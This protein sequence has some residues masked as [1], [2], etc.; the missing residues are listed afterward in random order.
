[1]YGSERTDDPVT[2]PNRGRGGGRGLRWPLLLGIAAAALLI[3][4][5]VFAAPGHK[6]AGHGAAPGKVSGPVVG[7]G[8]PAFWPSWGFT[9]TQFTPDGPG[10]A[11]ALTDTAKQSL[12]QDQAIMGWGADNPEPSPGQYNFGSLDRRIQLI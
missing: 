3:A 6:G 8:A 11:Q 12:A 9:H 7:G 2:A 1:M 4:P 5:I 10:L